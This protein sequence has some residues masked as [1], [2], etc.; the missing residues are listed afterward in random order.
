MLSAQVND[1]IQA[2]R[3]QLAQHQPLDADAVRQMPALVCF[4]SG[5]RVESD[6]LKRFL[7]GALYR[8]PQV[9][10]TTERA[11]EVVRA[12]FAAYSQD[13]SQLP[14]EQAGHYMQHGRR[15]IADYIA[16]MTDR[17]A[18]REHVRLTGRQAFEQPLP[19]VAGE[20]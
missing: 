20:F 11:R 2:T 19:V 10:R 14:P 5:M 1:V 17:F 8:H 13:P 4:S 6:R 18:C 15:V 7:F 12:L 3:Q 9:T 16:G